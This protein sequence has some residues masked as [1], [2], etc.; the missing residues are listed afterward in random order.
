MICFPTRNFCA[1]KLLSGTY[2]LSSLAC[3]TVQMKALPSTL[4]LIAGIVY[5]MNA[6]H[7]RPDDGSAGRT[8]QKT[9]YPLTDDPLNA[10]ILVRNRNMDCIEH[11][12]PSGYPYAPGG[13]MYLRDVQLPPDSRRIRFVTPESL[14]LCVYRA[15]FG[16]P[17]EDIKR[18]LFHHAGSGRHAY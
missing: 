15:V 16:C 18:V 7:S 10:H 9:V 11:L 5:Q 14:P 1:S 8:I 6:N 2:V 3:E 17:A 4:S 12:Y 13:V